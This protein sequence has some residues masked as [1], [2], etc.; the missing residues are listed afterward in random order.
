MTSK[1]AKILIIS[2][3]VGLFSGLFSFAFYSGV[4]LATA[5]RKSHSYLIYFLPLV[6]ILVAW[7][8]HHFGKEVER[9]NGLILEEIH[10]PKKVIP[11]R[12][13]PM[14]MIS[15][16]LSHLFGASVGREGTAVQMGAAIGDQFHKIIKDRRILLMMG[17]SAGFASI[18][19]TPLTGT[20]FAI[21]IL[22]F[23]I[24]KYEVV[25]PCFISAMVGF[26]TAKKLGI[27]SFHA[28]RLDIPNF[29]FKI[30]ISVIAA[31]ILFGL[32][33]RLFSWLVH[34]IKKKLNER[35]K[36]PI[37]RPFFGGSFVVI[38]YLLL[39]HDR[40]LGLG[41]DIIRNSFV[42]ELN[43]FDFFGKIMTTAFSVGSGFKG[44][45]VMSLF[46]IGS[47]MGNALSYFL[48]GP[49]PFYSALGFICVF[50][51]A[52]NTPLAG[53]VMAVELFSPA[54]GPYAALAVMMSYFFSGQEGI[55]HSERKKS[56]LKI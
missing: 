37:L 48:A 31:G 43:R 11:L 52:A 51:G 36:N 38:V 54:F 28:G 2:S 47:T 20:I 56:F 24:V 23:G 16:I 32:A 39:G 35:I 1:F 26:F 30:L 3:I 6:G 44:G 45:E 50:S 40:Y 29:E 41:E 9:G 27:E 21:E 25:I 14:V 42:M 13:A 53:A 8:Y 5:F 46:Y 55:Y 10:N 17:M 22:T 7:F 12:M 18:F 19:Q 49:L 4:N 15:A 34:F 33:A